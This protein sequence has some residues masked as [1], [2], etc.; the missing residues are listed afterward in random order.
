MLCAKR[1]GEKAWLIHAR[2]NSKTRVA[3]LVLKQGDGVNKMSKTI[4]AES[5]RDV[6]GNSQRSTAEVTEQETEQ[7]TFYGADAGTRAKISYALL[8]H[9]ILTQIENALLTETGFDHDHRAIVSA[10]VGVGKNA[11]DWKRREVKWF[12]ASNASLAKELCEYHPEMKENYPESNKKRVARYLDA[13]LAD[14]DSKGINWIERRRM[15]YDK[16]KEANPPNRYRLIFQE[17]VAEAYYRARTNPARYKNDDPGTEWE[18][19]AREV[20]AEWRE[21]LRKEKPKPSRAKKPQQAA[22]AEAAA[23]GM[24]KNYAKMQAPKYGLKNTRHELQHMVAAVMS[25]VQRELDA[26]HTSDQVGEFDPPNAS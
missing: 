19:A 14:Q 15:P 3:L 16:K 7:L 23:R 21:A 12:E 2:I 11:I 1:R 9:G 8:D 5:A 20:A 6:N 22:H 18:K 4:M 26:S 13:L 25:D 17:Y 10:L 24:L